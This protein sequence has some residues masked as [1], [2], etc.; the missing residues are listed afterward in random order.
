MRLPHLALIGALSLTAA[1]GAT[2]VAKDSAHNNP[3][4]EIWV[5]LFNGKDLTDWTIKIANREAGDNYLNTFRVADGLMQIRYDN[6]GE[7]TNDFGHIVY[8]GGP[9][10]HYKL[11]VEYRFVGEQVNNGPAWA[12]RNNGMM[13]HSQS[14]A[15]MG[16][17]QWFPTC[18][19]YQLLGGN[20]KDARTTGN[21][22]T[23][24]TNVVIN[25]ELRTD[26]CIVSNSETYHGDQWVTAELIV[27]GSDL[28][29]HIINGKQVMEY[30]GLQLDDGTPRAS[31][32]IALQA[33]SHPTDFRSVRL[34]NLEGC[35]D[36]KAK[37]FKSYLVKHNPQACEY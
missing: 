26:H 18:I 8:N 32:Y 13:Y 6:Y 27:H 25:G 1:C 15:E 36:K 33:E 28:A 20:G 34:L 21:L 19:E 17:T 2:T 23:P 31:G 5:D 37:N 14:A 16:L 9:Y 10:S 22:C 30:N 12:F 4:E 3:D 11:Q 7:F 35:M 29:Q 24:D